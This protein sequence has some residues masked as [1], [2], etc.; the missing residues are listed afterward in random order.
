MKV[1]CEMQVDVFHWKRL[2]ITSSGSAS[3]ESENGAQRRLAQTQ[4]HFFLEAAQGL[5]E[6]DR[7]AG[8]AVALFGRRHSG[9]ADELAL[10]AGMK[11]VENLQGDFGFVVAVDLELVGL[12][13]GVGGDRVDVVGF[14]LEGDLKRLYFICPSRRAVPVERSSLPS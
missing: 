9:D 1:T 2:G 13:A 8:L 11:P 10:G 3:F 12:D 14:R 7:S 5:C 6:P 4:H